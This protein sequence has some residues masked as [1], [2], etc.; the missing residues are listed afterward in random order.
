VT[1]HFHNDQHALYSGW[2][3]GLLGQ[4]QNMKVEPIT[5]DR[6]NW[7]PAFVLTVRQASGVSVIMTLHT[8]NPPDG[9]SLI[10]STLGTTP[11]E[12]TT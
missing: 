9:W 8:P 12:V 1:E 4:Q 7:T 11:P 2:I 6:G 10:R 3:M 5:D